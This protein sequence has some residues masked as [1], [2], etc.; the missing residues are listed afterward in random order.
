M[1]KAVSN[2]ELQSWLGWPTSHHVMLRMGEGFARSEKLGLVPKVLQGVW[3][4]VQGSST[5]FF[6]VLN[7]NTPQNLPAEPQGS[8][9]FRG[10][11]ET[12]TR[13]LRTG[14]FSSLKMLG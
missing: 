2:F 14:F 12:R 8:V 13:L 6:I 3:G 10:G 4:S 7:N 9:E 11:G 1:R 5:S